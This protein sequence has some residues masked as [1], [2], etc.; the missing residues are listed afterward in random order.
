MKF[1]RSYVSALSA[2]AL[3]T[4]VVMLSAACGDSGAGSDV[5][6]GPNLVATLSAEP[7]NVQ[8]LYN[9]LNIYSPSV[10]PDGTPADPAATK[11]ESVEQGRSAEAT[12]VRKAGGCPSLRDNPAVYSDCELEVEINGKWFDGIVISG[13]VESS[14]ETV[15]LSGVTEEIPMHVA[16]AQSFA[17]LDLELEDDDLQV[18]GW[19]S[20]TA[21]GNLHSENGLMSGRVTGHTAMSFWFTDDPDFPLA[22]EWDYTYEY[23][24]VSFNGD[25]CAVDGSVRMTSADW[26][27]DESCLAA[28]VVEFLGCNKIEANFEERLTRPQ[29]VPAD[30]W[31]CCRQFW[32]AD[33]V[34]DEETIECLF[35]TGF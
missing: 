17:S 24:S 20:Q 18:E 19:V 14:N 25:G 27:P 32:L 15:E 10:S 3:L 11:Q 8:A 21:A 16:A 7:G 35:E 30:E 34:S 33:S 29:S 4:C 31:Q 13:T 12:V 26:Y 9:V 23:D 28:G 6:D 2:R 22:L 5:A 1:Y